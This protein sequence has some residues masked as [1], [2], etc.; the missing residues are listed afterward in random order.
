[1]FPKSLKNSKQIFDPWK[2]E[3]LIYRENWVFI[4][5]P[6]VSEVPHP[7][8]SYILLILRSVPDQHRNSTHRERNCISKNIKKKNFILTAVSYTYNINV[9]EN[10]NDYKFYGCLCFIGFKGKSN[11]LSCRLPQ[12]K[13]F[14]GQSHFTACKASKKCKFLF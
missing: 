10:D 6:R 7:L 12:K 2:D 13:F 1:M 4:L 5:F 14:L 8:Y 9:K 11:P 3:K